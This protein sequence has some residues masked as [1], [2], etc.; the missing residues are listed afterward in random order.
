MKGNQGT[1]EQSYLLFS[2]KII[3]FLTILFYITKSV[4]SSWDQLKNYHLSVRY[5]FL[6]YSCIIYSVHLLLTAVLWHLLT[7]YRKSSIPIVVAVPAWFVSMWGKYLPGKI[8]M[9]VGRAYYY[10]K[11]GIAITS[12]TVNFFLELT[13]QFTAACLIVLAGM[14]ELSFFP[15]S[16]THLHLV[17][18]ILFVS[19]I[20]ATPGIMEKF[21]NI[22]LRLTR[23]SQVELSLSYRQSFFLI[24]AHIVSYFVVGLAFYVFMNAFIVVKMTHF[25]AITAAFVFAGWVGILVLVAPAGLGVREGVLYL[26]LQQLVTAAAATWIVVAAR[27]WSTL[28]EIL[29]AG[30]VI[31]PAIYWKRLQTVKELKEEQ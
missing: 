11:Y 5:D 17:L 1:K 19:I 10:K 20:L 3:I 12:T 24:A 28:C 29:A 23:R 16:V 31:I 27:L 21:T 13:Y 26:I 4:I 6:G 25:L 2:V 9:F 15:Q 18:T 22:L 30:I 14:S 7:I 8:M